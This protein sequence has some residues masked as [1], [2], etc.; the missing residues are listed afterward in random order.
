[1]Y[2]DIKK[3]Q[4]TTKKLIFWKFLL[5]KPFFFS[6]HNLRTTNLNS[7][8]NMLGPCHV[9]WRDDKS[10]SNDVLYRF[11]DVNDVNSSSHVPSFLSIF[12]A[13][14]NTNTANVYKTIY[15]YLYKENSN[16]SVSYRSC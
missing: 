9:C 14:S 5:D 15:L 7:P 6:D 13:D 3:K 8:R 11:G 2:Y 16:S 12:S 4:L 10:N 1:M